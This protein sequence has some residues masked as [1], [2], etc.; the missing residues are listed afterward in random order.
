MLNI[1]FVHFF[2]CGAMLLCTTLLCK[3][4]TY[5]PFLPVGYDSFAI[6]SEAAKGYRQRSSVY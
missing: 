4:L 6:A 3:L 1:S 2:D 5:A